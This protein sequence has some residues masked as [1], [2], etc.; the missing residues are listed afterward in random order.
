M[1]C[2][3]V[4]VTQMLIDREDLS[5][6]FTAQVTFVLFGHPDHTRWQM[7]STKLP[8]ISCLS[9]IRPPI[10]DICETLCALSSSVPRTSER[11]GHHRGRH[12]VSGF[13]RPPVAVAHQVTHLHEGPEGV[14]EVWERKEEI[15]VDRCEFIIM[16]RFWNFDAGQQLTLWFPLSPGRQPP[17]PR[18]NHHRHQPNFHW[19]ITLSQSFRHKNRCNLF[20][21]YQ[22]MYLFSPPKKCACLLRTD[23][24]VI[25]ACFEN[26]AIPHG[27]L[28]K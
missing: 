23:R 20:A 1:K 3:W 5:L 25:G 22:K 18:C 16:W 4:S 9:F 15:Q 2:Q 13:N 27:C 26:W 24:K 12:C 8:Y 6:Q 10:L 7:R 14:Q 17:V 21:Y 11:H 28:C 19:G